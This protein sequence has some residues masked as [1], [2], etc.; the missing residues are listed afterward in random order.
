MIW[1]LY[2]MSGSRKFILSC[3]L[4]VSFING[5]HDLC[6]S[7]VCC[8]SFVYSKPFA[9]LLNETWT[10]IPATRKVCAGHTQHAC[11]LTGPYCMRCLYKVC[12]KHTDSC[13]V[14]CYC[15]LRKVIMLKHN[16]KLEKVVTNSFSN[17]HVGPSVIQVF[18]RNW[19]LRRSVNGVRDK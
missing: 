1:K 11:R 7:C 9:R 16:T 14:L 4:T 13:V 15:L 8:R 19:D 3:C 17:I 5:E 10:T 6:S 2:V 18:H 12:M